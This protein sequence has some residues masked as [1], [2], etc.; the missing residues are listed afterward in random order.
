MA[1]SK[2][3][4]RSAV[5]SLCLMA[6]ASLFALDPAVAIPDYLHTAWTQTEGIDLPAVL[7]LAQTTDGYLWLGSSDGLIRFDGMRFVRWSPLSGSRLAD[8]R[9][10]YL[11]PPSRGGL[12]IGTD[13][14]INRLYRGRIQEYPAAKQWLGGRVSA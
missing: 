12:W 1:Y 6:D 8:N 3:C 4:L 5:V 14:G 2:I 10:R 13:T 9:I 11:R 7:A